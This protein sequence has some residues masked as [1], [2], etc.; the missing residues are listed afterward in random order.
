MHTF[1]SGDVPLALT[2]QSLLWHYSVSLLV[3]LI[4]GVLVF[5]EVAS[6]SSRPALTVIASVEAALEQ[7]PTSDRF[8]SW[9][10]SY[11][12]GIHFRITTSPNSPHLTGGK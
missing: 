12:E 6:S 1:T 10:R 8:G 11:S 7:R 2:L 9:H 4:C 3:A 5:H